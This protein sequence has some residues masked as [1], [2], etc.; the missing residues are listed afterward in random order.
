[1]SVVEVGN[2]RVGNVLHRLLPVLAM[3][4]LLQSVSV[5]G[6][7]PIAIALRC[8]IVPCAGDSKV[9]LADRFTSRGECLNR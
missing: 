7:G 2:G 5:S 9:Q 1:M 6:L 4:S 3:C 8:A